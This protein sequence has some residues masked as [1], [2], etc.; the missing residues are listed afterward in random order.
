[1]L[2]KVIFLFCALAH[3][4]PVAHFSLYLIT[5]DVVE[6]DREREIERKRDEREERWQQITHTHTVLVVK[7]I[8]SCY[9]TILI[10]IHILNDTQ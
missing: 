5:F 8:K 6:G 3:A 4:G 7:I 2:E 9:V 10:K 1:M